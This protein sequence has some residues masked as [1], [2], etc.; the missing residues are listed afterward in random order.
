MPRFLPAL[1]G[2]SRPV[3]SAYRPVPLPPGAPPQAKAVFADYYNALARA[4]S[5]ARHHSGDWSI[6]RAV[7]EGY[8]RL[9]WGFKAVQAVAGASSSLQYRL[10]SGQDVVDDDPVCY[11]LNVQANPLETGWV[12]RKRLSSQALIS[13][14]GVFVEVGRSNRGT[15]IR[16]DLLPPT[17]VRIV[18]GRN[19]VLVDHYELWEGGRKQRDLDPRNV[20]WTRDPHPTD[21]YSGVTPLEAAGLSIELDHFARLYNVTFLRNDGRPGG[22]VGVGGVDEDVDDSILDA[23]ERR[24]D[25]GPHNA[26]KL[27][28]VAGQLSYVDLGSKPRDAQ[29]G[30]LAH[31]AKTE[32]LVAFGVPESQLGNAADR[33][34]A[35]AEQEGLAFWTQTMAQHNRLVVSAF[36][37]DSPTELRGFLDT[38]EIEVLQVPQRARRAEAREEVAAGLRSIISYARLA[39]YGD[40]VDDTA[41]TRALWLPSGT[42]PIP[43][44]V[45]DKAEVE[46]EAAAMKP[47]PATPAPGTAPPGTH[48]QSAVSRITGARNG[49]QPA[50]AGA[51]Q[52]LAP[53]GT[54]GRPLTGA[55][56]AAAARHQ[57]S[58]AA[59]AAV[60]RHQ[61]SA[62]PAATAPAPAGAVG[63]SLFGKH[64]GPDRA[65][66]VKAAPALR[67]VVDRPATKATPQAWRESETDEAHAA[68]VEDQVAA[69]LAALV[70]RWVER[71][72]ARVQAP[73]ARKGTRHFTPE[74]PVDTRVGTRAL[75]ASRIVDED[76]F[77][78]EAQ[79]AVLPILAAALS[80]AGGHLVDDL[81]AQGQAEVVTGEGP[82]LLGGVFATPALL[83]TADDQ[84]DS[85]LS[86]WLWRV[87][88]ARVLAP[89][90]D[91]VGT[92]AHRAAE[93]LATTVNMVDQSGGTVADI[94]GQ[95]R[96][97][98][99]VHT[100]WAR[101]LAEQATSVAVEG[102]RYETVVAI[103]ATEADVQRQ[104]RTRGDDRVRPTHKAANRQTAAIGEPFTVGDAH[105]LYPGDPTGPAGETARCRCRTVVRSRSTGRFLP[106]S[107]D[108]T[109]QRVAAAAGA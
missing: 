104:W 35:N 6:E 34:F 78:T 107:R 63:A 73:K 16:Y 80:T 65:A 36:E 103:S 62:L 89:L 64:G 105:L 48:A 49:T 13:K 3:A 45:A 60:A 58:G 75:D 31:N 70:D 91:L 33:T 5:G 30:T 79:A 41:E 20:H 69:A 12:F 43:S 39:G 47:A 2:K 87:L 51:V 81:G 102:G 8:E 10:R 28:A 93:R 106:G 37:A 83:A 71:T 101:G 90:L 82:L 98:G 74:H 57:P 67:L 14:P 59:A 50:A 27:T 61:P 7:T 56:A 96:A 42:T 44:R 9:V 95:V 94:E 15:P 4:G 76:R 1:R 38:S 53:T 29:Y 86:P 72:V 99:T 85:G 109:R 40:E 54:G 46:A 17:K 66:E 52:R 100:G 92:S 22:I 23:I 24:F 19:G 26:G 32:I 108:T 25:K 18:P 21:P 77:A 84:P 88:R 11:L 97:W 55:A 68:T